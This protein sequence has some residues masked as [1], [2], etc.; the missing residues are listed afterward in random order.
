MGHGF[1][2]RDAQPFRSI[3]IL[4]GGH[5][6][7]TALSEHSSSGTGILLHSKHV[8][9]SIQLHLLVIRAIVVYAP[10]AGYPVED[11]DNTFDQ[12]RCVI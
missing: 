4:H 11:F 3:Y 12:L 1:V 5:V 8:R 7:F 10:H 2:K 6:L 9:K